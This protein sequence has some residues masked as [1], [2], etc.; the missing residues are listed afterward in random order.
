VI[1]HSRILPSVQRQARS[2]LQTM[3]QQMAN[4]YRTLLLRYADTSGVIPINRL[5]DVRTQSARIVTSY[6][7]PDGRNAYSPDNRA[8]SPFARLLDRNIVKVIHGV[9]LAHH[10][11]LQRVLPA[12]L[13]AWLRD[14][15]SVKIAES[16][17]YRPNPL[18]QYEHS[19][20]WIDS[21]GYDL[22]DRIWQTGTETRR[23]I[24]M[25]LAE[26]IRNGD[27]AVNIARRLEQYLLPNR[28]PIRT[29]TPYGR[30]GS[31]DALRLARSEIT[32]AHS[33]AALVSAQMNPFVNKMRWNLSPSHPKMDICDGIAD[34]SPYDLNN[35][36]VPV[37]S[38]HSQCMCYLTPESTY[39]ERQVIDML[40]ADMASDT[41]VYTNPA[42]G[43]AF[44]QML[45]GASL[46]AVW[47]QLLSSGQVDS[48][49][50]VPHRIG[51]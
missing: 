18:L 45:L 2:E 12:D 34:A 51:S 9:V 29:N 10:R 16:M 31:Y 47:M 38:S 14:G 50:V 3:F 40:R 7:T 39:T 4:E 42:N 26:G 37:T 8:L 49:V 5:R 48:M 22:S 1:N 11:Y 23:K 46:Y 41:P 32:L 25:L 27:S 20:D 21:R 15:K 33:R 35:C 30:D 24:D 17:P 6:F 44:L 43:N 13:N 19:H 28:A 36:P